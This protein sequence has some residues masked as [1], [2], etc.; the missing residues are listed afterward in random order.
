MR[1]VLA[2]YRSDAV[3]FGSVAPTQVI[4]WWKSHRTR[5]QLLVIEKYHKEDSRDHKLDQRSIFVA[6][7]LSIMRAM[8]GDTK[9]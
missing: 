7:H 8:R 5:Q 1:F 6:T 9:L 4:A 3:C 2:L